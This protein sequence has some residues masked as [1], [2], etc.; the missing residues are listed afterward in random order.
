R[1]DAQPSLPARNGRPRRAH[2]PGVHLLLAGRRVARAALGRLDLSLDARS[3]SGPRPAPSDAGRGGALPRLLPRAGRHVGGGDTGGGMSS[4]LAD[5]TIRY[6][7]DVVLVRQRA[8]QIA[9]LVGFDTQ[10]QTRVATAVSEIARNAFTYARGG[11]VEFRLEGDTI[12]QVLVMTISDRG[13]GI[14]NLP[15]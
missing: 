8:R 15:V 6:E 3:L 7:R 11:Q 2:H 12:P 4:V 14:Q 9:T 13:P 10:D 5:L 1:A